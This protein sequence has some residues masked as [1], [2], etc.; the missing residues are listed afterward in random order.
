[1][2]L[3]HGEPLVDLVVFDDEDAF[4]ARGDDGRRR[5]GFGRAAARVHGVAERVVE[6]RLRDRLD[7]VGHESGR[8][9]DARARAVV[10]RG[11]HQ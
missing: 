1:L 6:R 11:H 8:A 10:V 7:Q 5:R 4:G 9:G 2:Q 3:T